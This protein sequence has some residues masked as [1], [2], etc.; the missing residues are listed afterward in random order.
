MS[1]NTLIK[2]FFFLGFLV[3]IFFGASS[4]FAGNPTT[5]FS[6]NSNILDPGSS[7]SPWGG[8]GPLDANCYVARKISE[9][10][11]K[12]ATI[13]IINTPPFLVSNSLNKKGQIN[14]SN[15]KINISEKELISTFRK[16]ISSKE[17]AT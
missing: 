11:T 16:L 12:E 17:F 2:K 3:F 8:C 10:K 6:S 4:V 15:G 14:L 7:S 9:P 1:Y 5:F 13:G